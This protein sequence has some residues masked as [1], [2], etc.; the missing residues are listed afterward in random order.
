MRAGLRGRFLSAAG[1]G[2]IPAAA[3]AQA[4][5]DASTNAPSSTA[6]GPR[7]LQNFSLPGTPAKP[8]EQPAA[9]PTTRTPA[10]VAAAPAESRPSSL[11]PTRRTITTRSAAREPASAPAPV[12][13]APAAPTSVPVTPLL[14]STPPPPQ[15]AAASPGPTASIPATPEV[16]AGTLAPEH[17]L[18]IL[19]WLA[20]ALALA[21]GM[22]FLLWRRR[23]RE[24]YAGPSF[25]LFAPSAPSPEVAPAPTPTPALAPAPSPR[26]ATP[27]TKPA[28]PRV[29]TSRLRPSLEINL[30]PLRCQV[31]DQQVA[32]EFELELF[33]SGNAPA[34]AIHAEATLFNPG[35][36][37]EQELAAFFARANPEAETIDVIA[38]MKRIALTS[39]VIA[40]RSAI[41]EYELGGR[42]AFVPL[43][44]FNALYRWSGGGSAQT[45][46]A[47]LVG[48]ETRSD[49][50]G[51]LRLDSGSRD[52]RG[53]AA[54]VLPAALRT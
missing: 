32:V 50:L 54:H 12:S 41:Q 51:P 37:Q 33:N 20:S 14:S 1:F 18:S 30:R 23:P 48:R 42:K 3:L 7:E 29:V 11:A 40:P 44:A 35:A 24:S 10:P 17:R 21:A 4:V 27:A 49:K 22:L 9:P 6:I 2:L 34:R 16:P 15:A 47:Y 46:A 36:S 5:P 31:D 38:P 8:V 26:A 52:F 43:I 25:D 39:R 28:A 13:A 53:L 19:P 45:S